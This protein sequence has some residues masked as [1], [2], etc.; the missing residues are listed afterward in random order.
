[1]EDRR[2][3]GTGE[4]PLW[5]ILVRVA[6]PGLATE[7]GIAETLLALGDPTP[8][9]MFSR[10]TLTR[11]ADESAGLEGEEGGEAAASERRRMCSF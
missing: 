9:A 10:S 2:P 5:S 8:E 4:P 7:A 6:F 11:R 3:P 1:M